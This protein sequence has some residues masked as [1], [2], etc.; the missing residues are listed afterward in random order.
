MNPK[1]RLTEELELFNAYRRAIQREMTQAERVHLID[2]GESSLYFERDV[3]AVMKSIT[4]SVWASYQD[5]ISARR[6]C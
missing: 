4:A 1:S 6:A 3:L 5:A 2:P